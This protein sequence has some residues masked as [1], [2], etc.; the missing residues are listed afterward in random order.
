MKAR[1]TPVKLSPSEVNRIL[2]SSKINPR[3]FEFAKPTR[4]APPADVNTFAR[5]AF[6]SRWRREWGNMWKQLA[7]EMSRPAAR[8]IVLRLLNEDSWALEDATV[9]QLLELA[10]VDYKLQNPK[11]RGDRLW[12]WLRDKVTKPGHGDVMCRFCQLPLLRDMK[13][14]HDYTPYEAVSAHV[15]TC[16][17]SSLATGGSK[18]PIDRAKLARQKAVLR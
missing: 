15:A 8:V 7:V 10:L 16:A 4:G 11:A 12:V 18:P 2:T 3:G 13:M 14:G 17:L 5:L 9:I 1:K 6:V